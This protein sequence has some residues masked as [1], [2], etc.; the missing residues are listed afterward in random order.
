MIKDTTRIAG[1]EFENEDVIIDFTVYESCFFKKC[2]IIYYGHGPF[3]MKSDTFEDCTYE[4]AGPA[5]NAIAYLRALYHGNN[6]GGR[7]LVENTFQMIRNPNPIVQ[8]Q[9]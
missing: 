5:A 6:E 1:Y 2:R 4:L 8:K 3:Q 7:A 9:E